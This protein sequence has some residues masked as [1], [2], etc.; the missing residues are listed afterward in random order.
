MLALSQGRHDGH[1]AR[2]DR[3][4]GDRHRRRQGVRRA[5]GVQRRP[6][7]TPSATTSASSSSRAPG[8]ACSICIGKGLTQMTPG[9]LDNMQAV[10]ADADAVRAELL[11]RGIDVSDVDEQP[12]DGSS[13]QRYRRQQAGPAATARTGRGV[14][15]ATACAPTDETAHHRRRR[16]AA[17]EWLA[18]SFGARRSVMTVTRRQLIQCGAAA[19]LVFAGSFTIARRVSRRRRAHAGRGWTP[20]G[21]RTWATGYGA[22]VP[23]PNGV[24]DLPRDSATGSS[25]RPESRSPVQTECCRM[26]STVGLFELDGK[27]YLVRNSEQWLPDRPRVPHRR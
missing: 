6:R 21:L 11:D 20:F 10:V 25:P 4:A 2:T 17:F 7:T 1:Q 19:G 12:W 3:R 27:R 13:L 8:S 18:R 16:R 23:D 9:S 15:A 26:P 24:L 5:C 22:L 14:R